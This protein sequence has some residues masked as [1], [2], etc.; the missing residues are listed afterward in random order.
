MVI[1]DIQNISKLRRRLM[2][3]ELD[4]PALLTMSP[5]ELKV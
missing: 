4:P 2:D 1:L 3:K 5:D